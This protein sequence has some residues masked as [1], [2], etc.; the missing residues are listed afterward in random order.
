MESMLPLNTLEECARRP[1]LADRA[2]GSAVDRHLDRPRRCIE[3]AAD[4]LPI[5]RFQTIV[6]ANEF[7]PLRELTVARPSFRRGRDG[8]GVNTGKFS[9]AHSRNRIRKEIEVTVKVYERRLHVDC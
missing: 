7:R 8:K 1:P 9:G 6:R 3:L 5:D 4:T 2:S